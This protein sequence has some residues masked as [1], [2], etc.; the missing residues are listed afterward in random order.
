[1]PSIP[2]RSLTDAGPR[3]DRTERIG[4]TVLGV[5]VTIFVV[6]IL[7][8]FAFGAIY[9]VGVASPTTPSTPTSSGGSPSPATSTVFVYQTISFSP[10]QGH[11]QY[12][13]A[14]FT[15][16]VGIPVTF[17]IS[18]YDNGTNYLPLGAQMVTGTSNGMENV[19]GGAPGTPQGWTSTFPANDTTHTFTIKSSGLNVNVIV[20]PTANISYPVQ[21]SFTLT[22]SSEGSFTWFCQAPCDPYSMQTPGYMSGT[23]SV[24]ADT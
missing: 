22:F 13:P 16:P 9:G 1:M 3:S 6:V 15:V 24:V 4:A 7:A 17:T 18:S 20:P 11:D 8:W 14:N 12:Y 21:V 2:T 23:I 5:G 19:K 10:W